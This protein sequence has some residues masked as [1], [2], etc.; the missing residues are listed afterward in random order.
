[1][2]MSETFQVILMMILNKTM[3][4]KLIMMIKFWTPCMSGS[5]EEMFFFSY[6]WISVPVYVF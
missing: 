4:M 5:K 6:I 2:T 1:M 3:T